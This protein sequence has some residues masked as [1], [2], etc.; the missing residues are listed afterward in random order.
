MT[1]TCICHSG[2]GL[3]TGQSLPMHSWAPERARLPNGYCHAARTGPR[4][5]RVSSVICGSS[6]AHSAW[7]FA[8]T[9]RSRNRGRSSGWTTWMCAMWWRPGPAPLAALAAATASRASR[10]ARSPMAWKWTW[11]PAA[12]MAVTDSRSSAASKKLR[13]APPVSWPCPSRYGVSI[14]AVKFSHTPSCMI[15]MLVAR[16]RPRWPARSRRSMRPGQLLGPAAALP[17]QRADHPPGEQSA[18]VGFQVGVEAVRD[19][20][21]VADD[22]LLPAGDAQRVQVALAL[23]DAGHLV[24]HLGPGHDPLDQVH[25]AFLQG[26]GRA[27]VGLALDPAVG[28]VGRAGGDPGQLQGPGVGPGRVVVPVGQEHRPVGHHPVQVVPG[29]QA[30]GEHVH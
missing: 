29:R 9:S 22:G 23:D 27:A 21:V 16:N 7:Q 19:D 13:P 2:S 15:L 17:P 3:D 25:G 20:G 30:A 24:G 12:S 6:Q 28:W 14:E 26:A 4:N 1:A 11:N 10:T 5:G 18:A 8:A